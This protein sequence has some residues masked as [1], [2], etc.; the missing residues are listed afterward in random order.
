MDERE[1]FF[2]VLLFMDR[3]YYQGN[4]DPIPSVS[5]DNFIGFV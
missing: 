5:H 2:P 3:N 4:G 1:V